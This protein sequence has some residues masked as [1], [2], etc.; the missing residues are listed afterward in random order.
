M[1]SALTNDIYNGKPVTLAEFLLSAAR[2]LWFCAHQLDEPLDQV[3]RPRPYPTYE[4]TVLKEAQQD[5]D[6]I[7]ARSED[8]WRAAYEEHLKTRAEY[9]QR[10]SEENRILRQRYDAMITQ[11]EAWVPP[12]PSHQILKD[13]SLS[14][15]Y[16]S[17]KYDV[18]ESTLKDP[19]VF[20]D[21][22]RDTLSFSRDSLKDA[23]ERL[24][25]AE[26]RQIAQNA[27]V[28]ALYDNLGVTYPY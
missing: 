2:G 19:P 26:E 21:W 12:T 18:F 7:Q 4:K 15:L 13:F 8:D 28:K 16:E 6:R 5:F 20:D 23:E 11:V 1:P 14:Q 10:R 9:T 27:W 24:R 3:P 22:K 25:E 17:R